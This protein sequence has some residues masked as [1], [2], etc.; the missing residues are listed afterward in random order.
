MIS[1]E[2]FIKTMT[3]LQKLDHNLTALD[4]VMSAL[5]PGFCGFYIP[6]AVDIVMEVLMSIFNDKYEWIEYFAYELNYLEKYTEGCITDGHD[7]PIDLDSWDKVYDFL[8]ENM[9]D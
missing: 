1:K 6:D 9:E 7:N 4:E 3:R 2:L 5:S 8:I